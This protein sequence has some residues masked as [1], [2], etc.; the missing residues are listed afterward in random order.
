MQSEEFDRGLAELIDLARSDS[1]AMMC[2]ETLPWRCHRW[3][4]ADALVAR[5]YAVIHILNDGHTK[6]HHLT[7]FARVDGGKLTYPVVE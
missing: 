2:A 7:S 5:G 1:L 3:L 4:I 6:S